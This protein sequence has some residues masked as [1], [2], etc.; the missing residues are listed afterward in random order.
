MKS[1]YGGPIGTH[2]RSF[3]P[4]HSIRPHLPQDWGFA[5]PTPKLKTSIAII[6]GKGEAT[7]FKFGQ[8]IHRVHPNKSPLKILEKRERG[9]IQWLPKVLSTPYYLR[10]GKARN[11]KFCTHIHRIDRNKSPLQMSGKV[12]VGVLRA[13]IYRA[14]RAVIFAITRLSCFV[15]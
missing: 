1:Y 5:S 9:C 3:E 12:A 13:S 4:Q 8:N 11:F 10:K 6:S 7:D 14:H 2:Q 15:R